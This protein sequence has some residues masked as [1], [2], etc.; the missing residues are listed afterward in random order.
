M[1]VFVSWSGGKDCMFAT[2]KYL[3]SNPESSVHA[4]LHMKRKSSAH[5]F[6]EDVII[7]QAEAMSLPLIIKEVGESGYEAA[8][9]EALATLKAKGV[10]TGIFGDI[11]LEEHKVWVERVCGEMGVTPLFPLWGMDTSTIIN[12]FVASGFKTLVVAMRSDLMPMCFLGRVID[13]EFV[14]DFSTLPDVDLCGE[15]GEYHSYVFDGPLFRRPARYVGGETCEEKKHRILPITAPPYLSQVETG[16]VHIYT[17]TGKGK[18]TSAVGLA[19]RALG[20]G[21]R[22]LYCS[23]HKRPEKYQNSEI[24][25]LR[26]LGAEVFHFAKGHPGLDRRIDPEVQMIELE[27]ALPFLSE[28]LKV[29]QPHLLIMDEILISVRDGFL[30]EQTLIEFVKSKPKDTELVMTGRGATPGL[31]EIADYVSEINKV[32]HPFDRGIRSRKGIEC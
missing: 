17:G 26:R 1:T 28:K 27:E 24:D 25:S 9:K 14:R 13:E 7:E 11:Y 19:T 22:V 5:G 31:M 6:A 12:E 20:S 2:Y 29:T 18:T 3:R 16:L 23:F 15:H 21:L 32:K 4:L 8:F 10:D 30:P